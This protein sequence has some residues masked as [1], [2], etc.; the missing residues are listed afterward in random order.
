MKNT[1]FAY[2]LLMTIIVIS[3][4]SC[5]NGCLNG[6]DKLRSEYR[7]VAEFYGVENKTEY[8]VK[9]TFDTIYSMRTFWKK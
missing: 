1:C 5:E 7:V 2:I 6:N 4:S 8:D 3:L 9:I